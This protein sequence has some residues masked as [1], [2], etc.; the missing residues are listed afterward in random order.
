MLMRRSILLSLLR[1]S[2]THCMTCAATVTVERMC[3]LDG[4]RTGLLNPETQGCMRKR[5]TSP[6]AHLLHILH[7]SKQMA[8]RQGGEARGELNNVEAHFFALS[9]ILLHRLPALHFSRLRC[10][11]KAL[12]LVQTLLHRD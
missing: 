6:P 2:F 5:S 4:R 12:C 11:G 3:A 8:V 9:E 1:Q 10:T 7:K